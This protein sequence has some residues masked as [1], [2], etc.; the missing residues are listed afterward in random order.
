[1]KIKIYTS[2]V[3]LLLFTKFSINAQQMN[4]DSLERLITNYTEKD[5][6]RASTL[7]ITADLI[8][9][10]NPEKAITYAK[11]GVNIAREVDWKKGSIVGLIQIGNIYYVKTDYITA[12]DYFQKADKENMKL[13]DPTISI[14][15]YN[16]LANI[17]CDIQEY[18]KG[19]ENYQR[20][21]IYAKEIGDPR[22][23][24][25]ALTN[26]GN[27][28][29]DIEEYSKS[30]DY[31]E[32]ALHLADSIQ[33][34]YFKP[35]I[36]NNL[37]IVYS[38]L[39]EDDKAIEYFNESIKI[40]RILQDKNTEASSMLSY[41]KI[42]HNQKNYINAQP[43][44]EKALPLAEEV[45]NIEWQNQIRELLSIN[46]ENQKDF[47]KAFYEYKKHIILKDS[48]L[49][50]EKKSAIIKKDLEYEMEKRDAISSEVIKR[51]KLIKKYTIII[52]I[53]I[54]IFLIALGVL[55]KKHNDS[56]IARKGAEFKAD[57]FRMDLKILQSKL[58][59]HFIFNALNSIKN[60][61]MNNDA[62]SASTYLTKFSQVMRGILETSEEQFIT[63]TEDVKLTELY[64][65]IEKLRLKDKLEFVINLDKNLEADNVLFPPFLL[66][67]IIENSIWHGISAKDNGIG[68][69]E[70]SIKK[71]DENTLNCSVEDNGVGRDKIKT[72]AQ[73]KGAGLD[74]VKDR[75]TV[76]NKN[77][78]YEGK[79]D[80]ID[81]EEGLIVAFNL[82]LKYKF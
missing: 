26:I 80:I 31:L 48:V 71:K 41:A 57:M 37:G 44:L 11:E 36:L 73:T 7:L 74:I 68:K 29:T 30:K 12:L 69:I 27:V 23:E 24:A 8:T 22:Y 16:S 67:P 43:I 21:L 60:Y 72:F 39:K 77:E 61:V 14:S 10:N 46:Y 78:G 6:A 28:Y 17:Y 70:I 13:K 81:K 18:D 38:N 9:K 34:I 76:L 63:L 49:S 52:G 51:Q 33:Y 59:P 47:K 25:L 65:E 53:S 32:K 45:E 35:G 55:Y 3:F 82:P 2:F 1:M 58:N 62:S 75:I 42:L 4:L 50:D 56:I 19:I 79:I 15:I 5:S 40:S 64:L 66:Q 54:I 20:L